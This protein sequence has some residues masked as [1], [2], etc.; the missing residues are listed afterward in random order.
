M[1]RAN[2]E[3]DFISFFFFFLHFFSPSTTFRLETLLLSSTSMVI[4]GGAF[5]PAFGALGKSFFDFLC[6]F[7]NNVG[8]PGTIFQGGKKNGL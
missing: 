5:S 8:N 1:C 4:Y 2:Y 7:L 6:S 3:V